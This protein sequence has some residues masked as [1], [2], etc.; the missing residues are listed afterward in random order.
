METNIINWGSF[1]DFIGDKIPTCI[2]LVLNLCGYDTFLSLSGMDQSSIVA[3]EECITSNF[4][5]QILQLSCCHGEFYRSQM[6]LQ[7]QFKFLPGHVTLLLALS[8]Y[9][10]EYRAIYQKKVIDLSERY[11][12]ILNELI[13]TAEDN[14]FKSIHKSSYP[15]SI[16]FFAM[17]IYL[18]CGRNCYNM[19][20]ANLP[21]PSC[22]TICKCESTEQSFLISLHLLF[23][24]C[25]LYIFLHLVR[26]IREQ[27]SRIV[28]GE[29]W[30]EELH[31]S[32]K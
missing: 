14:Q 10:E 31:T 9:V 13:K 4:R 16:R 18:L 17:Y 3:I 30:A 28:E 19:L 21:M 20:N 29:I 22:S 5:N 23:T 1:E 24:I 32:R 6:S 2:K 25:A 11:S 7:I 15:D 26:Y 27:K 8:R 12:F